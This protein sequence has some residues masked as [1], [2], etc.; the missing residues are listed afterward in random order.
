MQ[1]FCGQLIYLFYF[2]LFYF[3]LTLHSKYFY[4]LEFQNRCCQ[5]QI[6]VPDS[7]LVVAKG[8]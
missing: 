2:V 8:I 7:N 4:S 1:Q 3:S 5:L 6:D